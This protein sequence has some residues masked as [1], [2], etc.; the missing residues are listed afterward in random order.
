MVVADV[1][2]IWEP[3]FT[4]SKWDLLDVNNSA[5]YMQVLP[6]FPLTA[7]LQCTLFYL[8]AACTYYY[9]MQYQGWVDYKSF[10]VNPPL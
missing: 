2:D 6:K 10:V 7:V 3:G 8:K 1:G 4:H 9:Y 5:E